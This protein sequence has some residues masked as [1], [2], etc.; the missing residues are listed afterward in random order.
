MNTQLPDEINVFHR[1]PGGGRGTEPG[2]A[3]STTQGTVQNTA[4]GKTLID[5]V[6]SVYSYSKASGPGEYKQWGYSISDNTS[7]VQWTKLELEPRT[8]LR[9]LEV[10]RD[11]VKGLDLLKEL[12]ANKDAA[13]MNDVPRYL[14][15]DSG[16]VVRDYLGK[17]AREW[18]LYMRAQRHVTETIPIDIVLTHPAVNLP[19]W[20]VLKCSDSHP[21]VIVLV[22]RG[23]E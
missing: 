23:Q 13:R 16:D 4:P 7:V 9:E 6:P 15:K 12:R 18:Y 8:T 17:V 3:R 11:L 10:L 19:F 5:K 2:T 20:H 14:P 21:A 22:V 1:W